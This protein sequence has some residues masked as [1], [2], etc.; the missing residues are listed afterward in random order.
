MDLEI[1]YD[2]LRKQV[3][4]L[5]R[6][7]PCPYTRSSFLDIL[8]RFTATLV[9]SPHL[10]HNSVLFNRISEEESTTMDQAGLVVPEADS[11]VAEIFFETPSA[12]KSLA[13][14]FLLH[15]L[16]KIQIRES[17]GDAS[18]TEVPL[19][20]F[21]LILARLETGDS[22]AKM[23]VLDYL[24]AIA[25][26]LPRASVHILVSTV[27]RLTERSE[28]NRVSTHA[29]RLLKSL[30]TNASQD[31][32]L[33][34]HAPSLP[35]LRGV[36]KRS[37]VA[38]PSL[39]EN[40]L[41]LWGP[42]M[43]KACRADARTYVIAKEITYMLSFIA[44]ML[45]ESRA[46]ILL[47]LNNM[48][49]TIIQPFDLRYASALCLND[50]PNLW[51]LSIPREDL[52]PIRAKAILLTYDILNDDDDEIR[53]VGSQ[54]AS[55]ILANH[56]AT[57]K[58]C[59]TCVPLIA[60]QQLVAHLAKQYRQSEDVCI[61]AIQKMTSSTLHNASL[62]PSGKERLLSATA[63]NIAL[64]VIEKQN[65]F[66][67]QYREAILW[68]QALK[69]LSA[70]AISEAT[71]SA[72]STWTCDGLTLLS[73]KVRVELDGPLGW[74]SKPEVFVFGMQVFCAADVLLNWRAR[75]T[76]V[77][78]EGKVARG[79]LVRLLADGKKN[80]VHG[81]W[82]EKIEKILVES[83]EKRVV[84]LGRVVRSVENSTAAEGEIGRWLS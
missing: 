82:L 51:T 83:L 60:S 62:V 33:F 75:T 28:D 84:G 55:Q 78:V 48:P 80:E 61:Q 2:L 39:A 66:I 59:Q 20:H 45:R 38:A 7:N 12:R 21:Q 15:Y 53:E 10:L 50:I 77:Q 6:E 72:L 46:S 9:S 35:S 68:S 26:S 73:E 17:Q 19:G 79:M 57:S 36:F 29:R 43:N 40:T 4:L 41:L 8:N 31:P 32:D 81:A 18:E 76:K 44:Q 23:Q 47:L 25:A 14:H 34:A 22:D 63:E 58:N 3:Q 13:L 27:T 24:V 64:F 30:Y 5:Y 70:K 52:T 69:R 37:P 67:D 54:I 65:L 42:L 1:I 74:V 56:G 71:A 49:L 11:E 16:L